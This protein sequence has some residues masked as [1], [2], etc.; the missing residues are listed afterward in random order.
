MS[1]YD[2]V[3][4]GAGPAGAAAALTAARGGARVALLD[5]EAFPRDKPC[6]DLLGRAAVRQCGLLGLDLDALGGFRVRGVSFR[7]PTGRT[8]RGIA[9]QGA[10]HAGEAATLPR[11][12]FD[13]ALVGAAVEAGAKLIQ[14]RATSVLRAED[15]AAYGVTM[16]G[17]SIGA[18]RG[19]VVGASHGQGAQPGPRR[20]TRG[21]LVEAGE[22]LQAPL[23]IGADGWGSGIARQL[24]G[25]AARPPQ[26][27]VAIRCYI[28]GVRGLHGRLRFFGEPDLVPGCAWIF[29]LA[30]DRANVGLGALVDPDSPA[31]RLE[32]RLQRFIR[33]PSSP[34]A[35]YLSAARRSGPALSWPLA[36]GWRAAP[37]AFDGAMLAGDA[38]SLISPMSGSGIAAALL[39]GRLAGE[40]ALAAL[41]QGRSS[42]AAL[43]PYERSVQRAL[44]LRYRLE[45]A[46]QGLAAAPSRLDVL[47]LL[48]GYVPY[49]Q[50]I[51]AGLLFN[52]G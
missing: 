37:L 40:T 24:L 32:E 42:R 38:A 46:G 9:L 52:L 31:P 23:L 44:R 19:V 34:A 14:G 12:H 48:A 15:G 45:R 7:T 6:G 17:S 47:G 36:L 20:Q 1:A 8:V 16:R 49:S 10:R 5:R 3:V 35:A 50:A 39:S 27:G 33:D 2:L 13:A 28:E 30:G 29:P 11:Y 41:A 22:A 26:R 4:V 51:A 18:A 25:Q 21:A 43:Q